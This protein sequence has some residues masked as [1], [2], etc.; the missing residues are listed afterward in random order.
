MNTPHNQRILITPSVAVSYDQRMAKGLAEGFN[1][2]GQTA[3]AS[4]EPLSSSQLCRMCKDFD[5]DIVVQV[6]RTRDVENPLPPN[7]RH[8]AWFQD[9]FPETL[10]NFAQSFRDSDILY[11]LGDPLVLGLHEEMPCFVGSLFTGVDSYNLN[12]NHEGI[13][14]NLDFSLCGGL[15]P[16]ACI[17][18][19]LKADMVYWIDRMFEYIPI[20]GRSDVFKLLR[21]S[22]YGRHYIVDHVSYAEMMAIINIVEAFYRPLRGELDIHQLAEA[23]LNESKAIIRLNKFASRKSKPRKMNS[24]QKLVKGHVPKYHNRSDLVARLI[25][26]IA[27]ESSVNTH[28]SIT[29]VQKAISYFS[30]SYPR[31]MDRKLLVD[32]ASKVS[33]SLELYGNGLDAHEFTRPYY[34]GVINDQDELLSMYCRSK[35]NLNNN[36]HGL[37]LHSRTLECMAVGG[38]IFMHD[39]P[40]D[41]KAG[42]MLTSFEPD[43]HYGIYNPENF[44]EEAERWLRDDKMRIQVGINAKEIIKDRHCWHHRAK[45]ILD[46]LQK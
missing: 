23:M 9:V 45:Q 17:S 37:G 42:G 34:K 43:V 11:A 2:M 10:N 5:I 18:R 1:Q 26:Y 36:T 8:V 12:F 39:S 21:R 3:F 7:V 19:N 28:H 40:H 15:P 30:Q 29:P 35:I 27:R 16:A 46:D 32:L 4:M 20:L 38:F 13:E 41:D 31:V 6:N 22:F 33:D 44:H 24:F 25:R 14:Q